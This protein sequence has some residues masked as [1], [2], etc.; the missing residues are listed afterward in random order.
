M[1]RSPAPDLCYLLAEAIPHRGIGVTAYAGHY[2]ADNIRVIHIV[3]H[4]GGGIAGGR[5]DIEVYPGLRFGTSKR[6]ES[7]M[8]FHC[9][10][11]ETIARPCRC[12]RPSQA[13]RSATPASR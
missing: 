2:E 11:R 12:T 7:E 13:R 4:D 3:A 1:R 5:Q 8:G 6:D 9:G 10:K